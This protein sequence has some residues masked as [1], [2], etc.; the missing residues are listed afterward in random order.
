MSFKIANLVRRKKIGSPSVK[1]VLL[2]LADKANDHGSDIW[3]AATTIMNATEYGKTTVFTALNKL[4]SIGVII[5]VGKKRCDNGYTVI[6]RIDLVALEQLPD[7][8]PKKKK[9]K[10]TSDAKNMLDSSYTDGCSDLSVVFTTVRKANSAET[11]SRSQTILKEINTNTSF[12]KTLHEPSE[13]PVLSEGDLVTAREAYNETATRAGWRLIHSKR[14][15]L[16]QRLSACILEAGGLEGW[17]TT[18]ARAEASDFLCNR[19]S[20]KTFQN[21][22]TYLLNNFSKLQ[23]GG[24]D[25]QPV[26]DTPAKFVRL[27]DEETTTMVAILKDVAS[28]LGV[29]VW[30]LTSKKFAADFDPALE[31][32]IKLMKRM[33]I[34]EAKARAFVSLEQMA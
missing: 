7:I 31:R 10:D 12:S 3:I 11:A 13:R 2:F 16:N 21:N 4:K 29:A 19:I 30:K 23:S 34:S 17:K 15:D 25:N 14:K 8:H 32:A 33:G 9:Q 20:G 28:D 18:L 26:P 27:P 6:Y 24:F 5:P 22:L 1:N